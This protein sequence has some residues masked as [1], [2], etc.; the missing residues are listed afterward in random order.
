MEYTIDYCF[1][2]VLNNFPDENIFEFAKEY[3]SLETLTKADQESSSYNKEKYESLIIQY[4]SQIQDYLNRINKILSSNPNAED[5]S[6]KGRQEYEKIKKYRINILKIE[7][8]IE[9]T[10][11]KKKNFLTFYHLKKSKS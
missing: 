3:I 5:E 4:N 7:K 11:E 1:D 10:N 9:S 8:Y 2:L 6:Y